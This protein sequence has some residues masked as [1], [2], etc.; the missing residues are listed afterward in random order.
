MRLVFVPLLLLVTPQ[1][2]AVLV[3]TCALTRTSTGSR[4]AAIPA[5]TTTSSSRTAPHFGERAGHERLPRVDLFR[6][7]DR[8]RGGVDA[9]EPA[10]QPVV[11]LVVDDVEERRRGDDQRDRVVRYRRR[12]RGRSRQHPRVPGHA[13]KLLPDRGG[14]AAQQRSALRQ[15]DAGHILRPGLL[16][17]PRVDLRL[18]PG[19]DCLVGRQRVDGKKACGVPGEAIHCHHADP[20]VHVGQR[21][22]GLPI[23]Q[24][25][26][27]RRDLTQGG[28]VVENQ[29]VLRHLARVRKVHC[30]QAA[31]HVGHGRWGQPRFT[32]NR[33]QRVY[34]APVG[35]PAQQRRFDQCRTAAHERVIDDVPGTGQPLDEETRQLR[36]EAGAVG[37]LVQAV[38]GALFRGPELVRE[39]VHARR[40]AVIDGHLDLAG[41]RRSPSPAETSEILL[42]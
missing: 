26:P 23:E 34:I 20:A 6:K 8:H 22:A 19:R 13:I 33:A 36:L 7:R 30:V 40:C 4:P 14:D 2:F 9:A 37:D 31:L 24:V 18:R 1:Q 12:V 38:R 39:R 11:A 15:D 25:L 42:E 10:P 27:E 32:E 16:L 35:L 5:G 3:K 28:R 21:A 17:E 29:Q 41:K